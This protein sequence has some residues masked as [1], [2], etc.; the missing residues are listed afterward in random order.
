MRKPIQVYLDPEERSQLEVLKKAFECKT[1]SQTIK[2]VLRLIY[3]LKV[4]L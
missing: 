2:K 3:N 1:Y 4:K